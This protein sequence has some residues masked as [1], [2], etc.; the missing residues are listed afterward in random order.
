MTTNEPSPRCTLDPAVRAALE[1]VLEYLW[2][3]EERSYRETP[4][5][6]HC[7]RRLETIRRWLDNTPPRPP[8][9]R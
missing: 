9:P 5:P 7:F 6:D 3:E 1:G 4:S 8:R 2:H